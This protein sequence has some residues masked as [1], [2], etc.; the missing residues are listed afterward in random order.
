MRPGSCL[1]ISNEKRTK[2]TTM[3]NETTGSRHTLP[4]TYFTE[5]NGQAMPGGAYWANPIYGAPPAGQRPGIESFRAFRILPVPIMAK[6]VER[7]AL[8]M[9][10]VVPGVYKIVEDDSSATQAGRYSFNAAGPVISH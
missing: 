10:Q 5:V 3:R 8:L 7:K 6:N 2:K 9:F 4:M 1:N